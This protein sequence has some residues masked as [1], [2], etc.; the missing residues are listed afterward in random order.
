MDC[1]GPKHA[2]INDIDGQ[3]VGTTSGRRGSIIPKAEL[4]FDI[5]RLPEAMRYSDSDPTTRLN[6]NDIVEH[7][8]IARGKTG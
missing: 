2:V 3:L 1:D 6:A 4:R 8:G 7:Q 5:T